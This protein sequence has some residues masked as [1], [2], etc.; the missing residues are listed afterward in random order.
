MSIK[1]TDVELVDG[2]FI[3]IHPTGPDEVY[4]TFD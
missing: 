1:E 3:L 4:D 2:Q